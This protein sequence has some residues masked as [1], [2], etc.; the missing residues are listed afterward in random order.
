MN[1]VAAIALA[2]ISSTV[3]FSGL[4]RTS[5]VTI[6][7]LNEN[8]REVD[9]LSRR[10]TLESLVVGTAAVLTGFLASPEDA[11]GFSNKISNQYDDRP[12]QRGSKVCSVVCLRG[13]RFAIIR[14]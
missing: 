7:A 13:Y 3:A 14:R 4:P 6:K 1:L 8:R 9:V 12:K 2:S 5:R 10:E 11:L